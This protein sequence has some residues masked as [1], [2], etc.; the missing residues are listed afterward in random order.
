MIFSNSNSIALLTEQASTSQANQTFNP[1]SSNP[2]ENPLLSPIP[3]PSLE[4]QNAW[5]AMFQQQLLVNLMTAVTR[6]ESRQLRH[7][8]AIANIIAVSEKHADQL[9]D[10]E[11]R[12][13]NN[14]TAIAELLEYAASNKHRSNDKLLC[15]IMVS[16][17]PKN[18][19]LSRED[20]VCAIFNKIGFKVPF[21]TA[22]LNIREIPTTNTHRNNQSEFSSFIIECISQSARDRI[23]RLRL[24]FGKLT[25]QKLIPSIDSSL[26]QIGCISEKYCHLKF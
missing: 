10:H 25:L 20:L 13:C 4:Q 23:L 3:E 1:T 24:D 26:V 8:Q 22:V 15:E 16:G 2:G 7:E 17:V 14:E 9:D 18:C 12:I 19:P 11:N 21:D 5:H 6:I